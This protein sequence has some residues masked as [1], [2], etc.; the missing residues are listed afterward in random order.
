MTLSSYCGPFSYKRV[1]SFHFVSHFPYDFFLLYLE[2]E[3][4]KYFIILLIS[5]KQYESISK[6][7]LYNELINQGLLEKINTLK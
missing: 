1:G 3:K 7:Y 6:I 4:N 5:E 2:K